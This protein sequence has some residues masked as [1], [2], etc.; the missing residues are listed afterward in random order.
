MGS[1]LIVGTA[2][3][4]NTNA[5]VER[6]NGVI[7]DTRRAFA[8]GRKDD[9]DLQLPLT[10]R[11][12]NNAASTLVTGSRLSSSTGA[13]TPVCRFR[14][15]P[16]AVAGASRRGQA[17]DILGGVGSGDDLRLRVLRAC[18]GDWCC[19]GG[20]MARSGHVQLQ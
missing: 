15:L 7:G 3:H 18:L 4:K 11:A 12:I 19:V 8:N 5:K 20:R 14:P 16:R 1:C 2:Y 6:A 9:W 13:P 17:S 10:V